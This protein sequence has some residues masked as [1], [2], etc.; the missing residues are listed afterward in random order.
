MGIPTEALKT[1]CYFKPL[2][3]CRGL[4]PADVQRWPL[5]E[6][7]GR[8]TVYYVQCTFKCFH[9]ENRLLTGGSKVNLHHRTPRGQTQGLFKQKH[10]EYKYISQRLVYKDRN[11]I[12]V[13]FYHYSPLFA[14]GEHVYKR[15]R[16]KLCRQSAAI[17]QLVSC[18]ILGD[19][20]D[21]GDQLLT[22]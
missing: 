8:S 5:R 13:D 22:Q 4:F 18:G 11:L 3:C 15:V 12:I 14:S 2:L 20:G 9:R 16:G 19:T 10:I 7:L 1:V 21:D 6:G 17:R